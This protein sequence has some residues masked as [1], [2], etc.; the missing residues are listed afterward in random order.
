MLAQIEVVLLNKKPD[1]YG[2]GDAASKVVAHFAGDLT[3]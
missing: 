2:D 3:A 1:A